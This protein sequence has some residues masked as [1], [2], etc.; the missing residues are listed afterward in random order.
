M[1]LLVVDDDLEGAE[2][3]SS[4]LEDQGH[5]AIKAYTA[6]ECLELFASKKPEAV[7]LDIML[8]DKNGIE[9][10]KKIKKMNGEIPVIM[11]TGFKDAENIV[12]AFREGA[13]DC[14]LKPYNYEYLKSDILPRIPLQKQ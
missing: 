11:V 3:L 9:V 5:N 13:F 7:F 2:L 1:L 8:P 10:L 14:L 12:S 4:F 6:Q